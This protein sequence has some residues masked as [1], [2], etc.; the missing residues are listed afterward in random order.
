MSN[1]TFHIP[2]VMYQNFSFFLTSVK[3]VALVGGRSVID[4]AYPA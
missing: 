4:V 2:Y 3:V 1:I